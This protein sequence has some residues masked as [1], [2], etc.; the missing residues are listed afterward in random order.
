MTTNQLCE[1]GRSHTLPVQSPLLQEGQRQLD[2]CPTGSWAL[3]FYQGLGFL[4][5]IALR[6][7][8]PT[9]PYSPRGPLRAWSC[10]TWTSLCGF[11]CPQQHSAVARSESMRVEC[12]PHSA[13]AG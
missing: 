7:T 10:H 13:S 12:S 5:A 1:P 11:P 9:L 8:I 6:R 3:E 4:I 2:S